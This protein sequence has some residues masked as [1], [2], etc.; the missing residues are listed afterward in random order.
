MLEI[1][2]TL[3]VLADIRHPIFHFPPSLYH[4]VTKVLGKPMVLILNKTDLVPSEIVDEWV[5]YFRTTYPRLKVV[6]FSN[7]PRE[8]GD[9]HLQ[10]LDVGHKIKQ[11][12]KRYGA[13]RGV[14]ELLKSAGLDPDA[15]PS[16]SQS[17]QDDGDDDN[18]DD[19]YYY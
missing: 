13:A 4:Y 8:Q 12:R 11:G 16:D 19:Y 1:S 9:L 15:S 2:D 17:H 5:A 3:L 6:A 14:A 10:G 18:D 7:Y